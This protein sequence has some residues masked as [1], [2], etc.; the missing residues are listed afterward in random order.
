MSDFNFIQDIWQNAATPAPEDISVIIADIKRKRRQMLRKLLFGIISL[1]GALAMI[2]WVLF[3]YDAKIITTRIGTIMVIIATIGGIVINSQLLIYLRKPLDTDID[4]KA[5]LAKMKA[6]QKKQQFMHTSGSL[7]YFI[8]LTTGMILYMFEFTHGKLYYF[9]LDYGLTLSWIA[10]AWF[11]LRP[12]SIRKE[13]KKLN[14]IIK[15]LERIAKQVEE[16]E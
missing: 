13:S 11:Y 1:T 2:V 16:G 9:V 14:T 3:G 4:S 15:H 5:Y 7:I 10:F 8:M 12:R 6:Y